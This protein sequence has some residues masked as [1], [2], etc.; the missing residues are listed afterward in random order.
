MKSVGETIHEYIWNITL[1]QG[2]DHLTFV[3]IE[4]NYAGGDKLT[5]DERVEGGRGSKSWKIGTFVRLAD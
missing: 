2:K 4:I 3:T 1:S 5:T